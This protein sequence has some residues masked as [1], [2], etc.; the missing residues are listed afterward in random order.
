MW[1]QQGNKL[2]GT[3]AVG[4]AQQGISVSLSSDGNTAIVGGPTDNGEAGAAWV[5]TRGASSVRGQSGQVPQQFG[6]EQNY[7]NPFNPTT[8]FSFN[9]PHSTFVILKIYNVLGREVATLVNENRAA[10][11]YKTQWD[12]TGVASGLYF[13]RLE[14]GEFVET[15][16]LALLR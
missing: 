4:N 5:Y 15:R 9:I 7:P 2:V 14:A 10:G 11:R 16:K 13:Y 12:A 3:G 8:T 6:L 1:T